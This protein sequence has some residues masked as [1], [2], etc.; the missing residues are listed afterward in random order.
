MTLTPRIIVVDLMYSSTESTSC[1]CG[2]DG[3]FL[4]AR[5]RTFQFCVLNTGLTLEK[6]QHIKTCLA[7]WRRG[8]LEHLWV[9]GSFTVCRE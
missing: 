5:L 8:E 4:Q 3:V 6:K 2:V 9:W 7:D 1:L